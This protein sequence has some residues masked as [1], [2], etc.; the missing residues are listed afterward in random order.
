MTYPMLL[1]LHLEAINLKF[2]LETFLTPPINDALKYLN[3]AMQIAMLITPVQISG[4][5]MLTIEDKGKNN[6]I[7]IHDSA[8]ANSGRLPLMIS[9]NNNKVIIG[10]DVQL[11]DSFINIIGSDCVVEIGDECVFI[12]A[13][14]ILNEA[15]KIIIGA[16]TT[17]VGGF[18]RAEQGGSIVV[19]CDCMF[20]GDI[21][22][23]TSDGH[24]IFDL[25]TQEIINP[26]K[27]IVIHP[28]VW[29]GYGSTVS[30][31]TIIG[32]CTVLGQMSLATGTLDANCIYAGVPAKK[33][34]SGIT[35]SRGMTY[36]TIPKHFR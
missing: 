25:E 4:F 14:L 19:G 23:R 36:D 27:D 21:N 28:R 33:I 15:S 24:G 10:K 6:V 16:K 12:R 17:W 18:C 32:Q 13:Q 35:W 29:L 8:T 31:G 3:V 5:K 20:S 1:H 22:I 2:W 30:K 7:D 11:R 26:P 34:R 9:G